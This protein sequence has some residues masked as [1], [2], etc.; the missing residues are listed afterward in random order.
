[1]MLFRHY[2]LETRRRA[3]S[4]TSKT[5][6]EDH[7]R[8]LQSAFSGAAKIGF[9]GYPHPP[10]TLLQRLQQQRL[11]AQRD[12]RETVSAISGPAAQLRG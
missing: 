9:L 10:Q 3:E 7:R 4:S 1:M 11:N 8:A 2:R 6:H 5:A 12:A